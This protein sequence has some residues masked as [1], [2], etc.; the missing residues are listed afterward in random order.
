[1]CRV[2]SCAPPDTILE[3]LRR[4]GFVEVERRVFGGLLSEFVARKRESGLPTLSQEWPPRRPSRRAP[5]DLP[6]VL[7]PVRQGAG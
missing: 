5:A 6:L 2:D 1:M 3:I 4:V 7:G